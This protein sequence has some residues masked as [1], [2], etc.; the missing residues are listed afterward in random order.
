MVTV[1]YIGNQDRNCQ[2]LSN[3][4]IK[5]PTTSDNSVAWDW[6]SGFISEKRAATVL[7]RRLSLKEKAEFFLMC[8]RPRNAAVGLGAIILISSRNLNKT[9]IFN[10]ETGEIHVIWRT[11]CFIEK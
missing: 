2:K 11:Q 1:F 4:I 10:C 6:L 7:K 3:K 9:N 5:P 8:H